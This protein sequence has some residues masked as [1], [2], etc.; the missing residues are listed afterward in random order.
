M[1]FAILQIAFVRGI[2]AGFALAAPM[3]PVAML[4]VRRAITRGRVQAFI[5]G[6]GAA[7]ADML[8]GAAAGL[9]ITVINAF[10]TNY[11]TAIGLIGGIIVLVI[12]L[13]TY[14][15]P[16]TLAHGSATVESL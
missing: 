10:V 11:E 2:I 1:N 12:G 14:R 4:C 8:F 13:A 15:A 16:I 7:L 3:G 9:G 6:L 5:T